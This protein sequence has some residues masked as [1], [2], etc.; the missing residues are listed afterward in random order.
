M[1]YVKA[2]MQNKRF[3]DMYNRNLLLK[4]GK[5]LIILAG[6]LYTILIPSIV[7]VMLFTRSSEISFY[8]FLCVLTSIV[9][10]FAILN[11]SSKKTILSFVM[12]ILTSLVILFAT[13]E[14]LSIISDELELTNSVLSKSLA[15]KGNLIMI[16]LLFTYIVGVI[17]SGIGYVLV[18]KTWHEKYG[19]N[20]AISNVVNS[21]NAEV[22]ETE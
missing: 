18:S 10:I 14:Y 8:H 17:T 20:K 16:G 22:S 5:L 19:D 6:C 12:L 13:V 15:T 7:D 9:G 2:N 1:F 11:F 4:I 21:D 3:R